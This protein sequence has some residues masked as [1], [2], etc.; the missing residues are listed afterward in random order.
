MLVVGNDS[1]FE[2]C[3]IVLGHPELAKDPRFVK[4]NDRVVHRVALMKILEDLFITRP[5][6][7]WLDELERAGVPAGPINDFQQVFADEQVKSRGME[8]KVKH[9]L[10]GDLSLIRNAL[11]FSET[12]IKDY[13]AP[14]LL[15]QNTEEV[16]K[17]K[18]GYSEA[19]LAELRR[20]GIIQQAG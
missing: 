11:T 20:S 12:P 9:P 13:R 16:L 15:G 14:P 18:L 19:K 17:D 6:K 2:K 1:Q 8:V 3:C 5:A 10:R 4:N 7:Y